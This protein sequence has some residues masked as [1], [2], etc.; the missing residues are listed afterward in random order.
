MHLR[1]NGLKECASTLYQERTTTPPPASHTCISTYPLPCLSM[2]RRCHHTILQ[3]HPHRVSTQTLPTL[4]VTPS[5]TSNTTSHNLDPYLEYSYTP[6]YIN[7][8][9]L[10]FKTIKE[11]HQEVWRE[12]VHKE[13]GKEVNRE[14]RKEVLDE[15]HREVC[16]RRHRCSD[17]C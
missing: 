12:E 9:Q 4:Q 1:I 16:K 8:R 11:V 10:Y 17:H 6:L 14:V 7:L 2:S 5:C 3:H 13:V 15:L